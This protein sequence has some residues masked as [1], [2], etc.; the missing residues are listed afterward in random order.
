LRKLTFQSEPNDTYAGILTVYFSK[1]EEPN[2]TPC[3]NHR[4]CCING[5][6]GV[7]EETA[8]IYLKSKTSN[9]YKTWFNKETNPLKGFTQ[10]PNLKANSELILHQ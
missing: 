5:S 6:D 10:L 9:T 7:N 8:T 2:S 1:T 4:V 3:L